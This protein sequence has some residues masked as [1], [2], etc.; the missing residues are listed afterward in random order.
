[1]YVF[2]K[3]NLW[4]SLH[5]VIYFHFFIKQHEKLKDRIV[6]IPV[7]VGISTAELSSVLLFLVTVASFSWSY[8]NQSTGAL[9]HFK[10][11]RRPNTSL[12]M[13]IFQRDHT[14]IQIF[15]LHKLC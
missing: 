9:T 10:I 11:Y 5:N 15:F 12:G 8:H 3:K 6:T 14:V 1:M 13:A 4:G 7:L 2:F